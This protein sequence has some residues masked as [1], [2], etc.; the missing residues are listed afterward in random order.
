MPTTWDEHG[1]VVTAPAKQSWDE[2][3]NLI[4]TSKADE[5]SYLS[6]VWKNLTTKLPGSY[7]EVPEGAGLTGVSTAAGEAASS[8]Q[9]KRDQAEVQQLK[10]GKS[11][12]FTP[13]TGYD[14]A[15]RVAGTVSGMA[16]PSGQAAMLGLAVAP[17]IAGPALIAH[18]GFTALKNAPRAIQGDPEA[19]AASLGGLAEAAGGSAVT[20]GSAATGA[21]TPSAIKASLLQKASAR[22]A[23]IGPEAADTPPASSKFNP[24]LANT[25]REVL[26]HAADM[27]VDLTAAQATK[28]PLARVVQAIGE[29]SLMGANKLAESL[30]A[31]SGAFLKQ[32]RDF[33][34]RM[35][36]KALGLS[37]E[38]AGEA[39]KQ[40]AQ[41]AKNVTHENATQGYK[42]IDYL[43]KEQVQPDSISNA[44]N[45]VKQNLPMGAEEQILA[46]TPR[47]MRAVIDDLLSGKPEGFKLTF[48]QGIKLRSLFRELGDTEGLPN[49][50]QGIMKSMSKTVD[51]AM[52]STAGKLDATGDWRNANAGWKDYQ[53]KY[54]DTQSPLYKI[55]NQ[56]DPALVTRG[57]L[58]R[59]SAADIM[60]MKAEGMDS[61]LEPLR[62][63]VIEDVARN[64]FRAGGN[65]LGG[66]SD[67]F[68]NQLFDKASLK[69]LYVKS[70][71][72]RR[73]NFQLNPSGTSNVLIGESQLLHPEPSK[74]GIPMGAAKA[75]MPQNPM[76]FLQANP[77]RYMPTMPLSNLLGLPKGDSEQ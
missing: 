49:S 2:N 61:A 13:A 63:Q 6:K 39:I 68:L 66:Y 26:T 7:S 5:P 70:D 3:G 69:E 24:A 31:N 36:P 34:D 10:S 17:Q 30:D 27:G 33:A 51:S 60:T 71:I 57:I 54:G 15:S 25:P 38:S 28:Q 41:T 43:M 50:A 44:W 37:E 58:N 73:F 65:G 29:R 8:L 20:A 32:T 53:S 4:A 48:E 46:Q 12:Y 22:L 56:R 42:Q 74:W 75:S 40:S 76:N 59:A 18:G 11:G 72:G 14:A 21:Y 9:S 16:S 67:S 23:Q 45:K 77:S 1:N 19:A 62:R 35:D 64:N 55:L 47:N 52:E